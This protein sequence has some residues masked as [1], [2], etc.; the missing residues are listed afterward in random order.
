MP[1]ELFSRFAG[2]LLEADT[3]DD[4][5]RDAPAAIAGVLDPALSYR[6]ER[7]EAGPAAVPEFGEDRR[8]RLCIP[9]RLG[10][11]LIGAIVASDPPG[12]S[13]PPL[14]LDGAV[15]AAV[16]DLV[17]TAIATRAQAGIEQARLMNEAAELRFDAVSILSHEMRTPL[18]SIKGYATALLMEDANWDASMWSEF[19][20]AIDEESDHLIRLIEDILE[21]AAIEAGALRIE[22]ESVL[23]PR[24]VKRV[25]DRIAIQSGRHRLVLTFPPDFPVVEADGG[26]I[27][28][29]VTNLID[30]AVKYSPDGGLIVVRGE[31]RPGEVVI[32]VVDQGVGIAPED[33]NQLFERFFRASPDRRRRIAGTGLGLPISEAIVRSHGGRIWAESKVGSGTT[34]AFTIPHPRAPTRGQDDA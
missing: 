18:A 30:N 12:S 27:E 29:V 17:A 22:L 5:M 15:V 3:V 24:I 26:R 23:L 21:S 25:V 10:D 19:L 7:F 9:L 20:Q 2:T 13:W 16:G 28:Q 11:R 14:D 31:V 32:S 1:V 33:L 6:I 4:V 34:L 8:E